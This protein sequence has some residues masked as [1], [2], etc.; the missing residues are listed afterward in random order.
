M[1]ACID[2]LFDTLGTF[3]GKVDGWLEIYGRPV[4]TVL[5]GADMEGC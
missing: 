1:V 3:V 4:G 5:G 2:G